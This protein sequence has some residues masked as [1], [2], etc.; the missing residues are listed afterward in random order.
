MNRTPLHLDDI[1]TKRHVKTNDGRL[2]PLNSEA[3]YRLRR[4]VLTEQPLCPECQ[5][6]GVLEVATQVHHINDNAMDNSREN[7]VGL[8]APCH[9]RHTAEDMG[10]RVSHGCD[11]QGNP[12]NP[13]HHWNKPS[14]SR[15]GG[16][17]G[18]KSPE[19]EQAEPVGYSYVNAMSEVA[20]E[21]QP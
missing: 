10:K 21:N 12:A 3:W 15:S 6:R 9:S 8:C 1:R 20:Y 14:Q 5:A 13:M 2:L 4:M 16:L 18:Q 17:A 11:L 19:A 7:L